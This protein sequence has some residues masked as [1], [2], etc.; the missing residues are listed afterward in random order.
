[1]D[2]TKEKELQELAM[3]LQFEKKLPHPPP[4][5]LTNFEIQKYYEN[6]TRFNDI[7]YRD[8][9]PK[10]IKNGAYIINLDE[11]EDVGTHWIALYVRNNEVIYFGSVVLEHVPKEIKIFIGHKTIKTYSEYR[12]TIQKCVDTFV[13][14]SLIL[15]FQEEVGLTTL[16]SFLLMILRRIMI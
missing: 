1:M 3:V 8:N 2:A 16:I 5:P 7:Y 9:L 11:Y 13:L 10:K 4:H 14:D 15:Y 6:E 12:H